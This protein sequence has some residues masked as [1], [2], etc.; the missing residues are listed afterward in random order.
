MM[1]GL[2]RLASNMSLVDSETFGDNSSSS[3]SFPSVRPD[4]HRYSKAHHHTSG[5]R[6]RKRAVHG[7][8]QQLSSSFV[9][10]SGPGGSRFA[11][12][13]REK[14]LRMGPGPGD[15]SV[16]AG[17]GQP[18]PDSVHLSH[19]VS[20]FAPA[21]DSPGRGSPV[22]S[23]VCGG[24]AAEARRAAV[25]RL[26]RRMQSQKMAVTT[27]ASMWGFQ[28][29]GLVQ[30]HE[31][32]RGLASLGLPLGNFELDALLE[33]CHADHEVGIDLRHLATSVARS[34]LVDEVA[35]RA[36]E[37]HIDQMLLQHF[38]QAHA[39]GTLSDGVRTR[40]SP[41]HRRALGNWQLSSEDAG[42]PV[43]EQLRNALTR[44]SVRVVDLLREWDT[45]LDG[46]IQF[47]EFE[48]GIRRLGYGA[49][50]AS[51]EA[52]FRSWDVD[53]SGSISLIE[54]NKILRRGGTVNLPK[55]LRFDA[56]AHARRK[57]EEKR[58]RA[59]GIAKRLNRSLHRKALRE[60]GP[61]LTRDQEKLLKR[62][63]RQ[64][65]KL[66]AF[67]QSWDVNH[68]GYISR[69]ELHKALPL[70]GVV[71]DK[72]TVDALFET[73]DYS[74]TGKIAIE[75][76]QGCMIWAGRSTESNIVHVNFDDSVPLI[77]QIRDAL[78]LNGEKVVNLFREFDE[79]GDGEISALEFAK[80]M[81]MLGIPVDREQV[82]DL[83]RTFD[84]R[85]FRS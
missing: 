8:T 7:Q 3:N 32:W 38:N 56:D 40:V 24:A 57:E 4:G 36:V 72:P 42:K 82:K 17:I 31:L 79:N 48:D 69:Q 75:H 44:H 21:V 62:L 10:V 74:L 29:D 2:P 39:R 53:G 15:Y 1:L 52:L 14:D 50:S 70:V 60:T 5:H 51:I 12:T 9:P 68:D 19:R 33:L 77:E 6:N 73:M 84:V 27:L 41:G 61:A 25:M 85:S 47:K 66:L 11:E 35:P 37:Q 34:G 23:L 76:L 64:K 20:A 71:A 46:L 13:T 58:K 78:T 30:K 59:S 16:P 83:F 63:S 43:Q 45:S 65:E 54:L 26:F 81:P 67:F 80:A 55:S 18:Q 22:R 28:R 49:D